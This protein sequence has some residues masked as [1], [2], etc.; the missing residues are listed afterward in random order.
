MAPFATEMDRS[1]VRAQ[2]GKKSPSNWLRT[3]ARRPRSRRTTGRFG[4]LALAPV[5]HEEVAV[6]VGPEQQI[7][8][9]IPASHFARI[10]AW[11]KS[12]NITYER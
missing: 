8:P 4:Y 1:L 7:T 6:L 3:P 12:G 11:M 9:T 2:E 5:R 10:R